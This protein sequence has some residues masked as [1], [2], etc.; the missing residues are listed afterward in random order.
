M[1]KSDRATPVREM[2]RVLAK[3]G[4]ATRALGLKALVTPGY[5]TQV[6]TEIVVGAMSIGDWAGAFD[7]ARKMPDAHINDRKNA[8]ANALRPSWI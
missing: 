5:R 7:A 2:A 4:E 6:L 3:L 1:S 8:L